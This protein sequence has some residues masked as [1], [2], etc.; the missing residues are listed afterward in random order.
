MTDC[1][2]IGFNDLIL[3]MSLYNLN[4]SITA[5]AAAKKKV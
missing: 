3:D 4:S 1:F 5:E 2:I